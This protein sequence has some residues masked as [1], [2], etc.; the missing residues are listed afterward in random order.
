VSGTKLI[1]K[2][3]YKVVKL[4]S[5]K[6]ENGGSYPSLKLG[7]NV[8]VEKFRSE[9]HF[10]QGP[11]RY[12]DASIVK[13]LEEKG[14][15]RPSTYASIISVLL[16]RYYVTRSN[17]QLVPTVLGK[18]I[19]EVLVE[20]F[21]LYV[22]VDF[23]A[24]M[25]TK[26]DEVEENK[27]SWPEMIKEFWHPFKDT[28]D[29]VIKT[30]ESYKGTLDEVTDLVCEKCEKPMMKKLGRFGYFLACSGFPECRNTKSVPLAKCPK[31]DGDIIARK[32]KGR[33]KEFYGCTKYPDCDFISHF[34]PINQNCPKCNFF[35]V[36]KYDKKNGAHKVCINPDCDY[37]H[38]ADGDE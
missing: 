7:N 36:E 19:Y 23:T 17:K 24:S 13:T 28:V 11:A 6:D 1:E 18:L 16:D 33:G 9:Q 12:S 31:C 14:I 22:D 37:L 2:G 38:S 34:K 21:P 25:E 8:K 3:F 30:V 20:H 4:L 35:M 27:V 15:G 10:T 29:E 5:S 26:L 32:T